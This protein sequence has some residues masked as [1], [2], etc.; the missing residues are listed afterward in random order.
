[1]DYVHLMQRSLTLIGFSRTRINHPNVKRSENV[2][3]IKRVQHPFET[4]S[5]APFYLGSIR[6]VFKWVLNPNEWVQ[7]LAV[8]WVPWNPF[9]E[10]H[11]QLKR[12]Q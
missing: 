8:N 11:P 10:C 12:V 3:P 2:D 7:V 4:G 9:I 1:M 5:V 6:H